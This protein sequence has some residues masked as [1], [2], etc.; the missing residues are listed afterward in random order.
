MRQAVSAL[1]RVVAVLVF[2]LFTTGCDG[3]D[4][5]LHGDIIII[6]D[7]IDIYEKVLDEAKRWMPVGIKEDATRP[8]DKEESP[9]LLN[10]EVDGDLREVIVGILANSGLEPEDYLRVAALS[11]ALGCPPPRDSVLGVPLSVEA[12]PLA[13][14]FWNTANDDWHVPMGLLRE[15]LENATGA[16]ATLTGS[17]SQLSQESVLQVF[18]DDRGVV[19]PG[20]S[21][22]HLKPHT[23]Q[24]LAT[25]TEEMAR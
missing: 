8:I 13:V 20:S 22:G 14:E 11:D 3:I 5:D 24:L 25:I 17:M 10:P 21:H 18:Y 6:E 16:L 9:I 7:F 12:V 23:C 19:V 2:A 1:V 4:I 15:D